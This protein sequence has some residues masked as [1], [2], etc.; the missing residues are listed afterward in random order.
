MS[1]FVYLLCGL[2]SCIVSID[3]QQNCKFYFKRNI[4]SGN[5]TSIHIKDILKSNKA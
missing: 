1:C 3:T 2:Y 5:N 4:T